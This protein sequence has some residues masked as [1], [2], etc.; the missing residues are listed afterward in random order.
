MKNIRQFISIFLCATAIT[1][2]TN[3]CDGF[4]DLEPRN[5]YTEEQVFSDA[6]L[7][8]A[9]VNQLYNRIQHAAL[10]HTTDGLTDDAYFTHN[11]GQVAVNQATITETATEW[12]DNGNAPWRWS[13]RYDGIYEANII[14]ERMGEVP[15]KAGYNLEFMKGQA[16][17]IRAHLYHELLRGFGGVPIVKALPLAQWEDMK[18]PRNTVDQVL[19]LILAD[20]TEA[21]KYLPVTVAAAQLG[22]VTKFAAT[23]LKA[24][25]QMHVASQLYH[26]RTI[27][28]LSLN[29]STKNRANLYYAA[30]TDA[31]K[32]IEEGP[33][34][35][36]DCSGPATAYDR[37]ELFK[38]IITDRTNSE[39]MF[40]RQFG[41]DAGDR[42]RMG[43]WHGPNGYNNWAGTTPSHDLVM[44]FERE[45][46]GSL[47]T[48]GMNVPGD[49]Y[50]A[51]SNSENPYLGREP[52]FYATVA[53][54][55]NEWGRAREAGRPGRVQDP[56][57]LGRLQAGHYELTA[58]GR[59]LA[60]VDPRS[61][62]TPP[63]SII[64]PRGHHGIDTRQGP[65]EDWNGSWTGYYERKLIDCA[66]EAR[67]NPQAVPWTF[68]RLAEMYLIA[69]EAH[70]ELVALGDARGNLDKAAEFINAVR[71]RVGN[72][73]VAVAIANRDYEGTEVEKMRAALRHERRVEFAYESQRYF[74]VRRWMIANETNNKELA[75]ILVIGTLKPPA[76]R[77]PNFG[78]GGYGGL[79]GKNA[80]I[81][82]VHCGDTWNYT[83]YVIRLNAR[84]NRK[85][86]NRLY[87]APITRGERQRHIPSDVE[88][89]IQNSLIVQNPGYE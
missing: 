46:D 65:I 28:T 54:D 77:G 81:P 80:T 69:A 25:I 70:I 4:M 3:G 49:T 53:T 33:F 43:L 9:Y 24:R 26:D 12:F 10:E 82:Y 29:Q 64:L 5:Q 8:Q 45:A 14:I 51:K 76:E 34:S 27:N 6:G 30:L 37:G 2:L 32:V 83:Y 15:D 47:Q 66:V 62:S 35:L 61:T 52:R 84:E 72:V 40:V 17:Y 18:T 60:I 16:Y 1:I 86:D 85:W 74:D 89:V 63:D 13:A 11:Y 20:L 38:A 68:M 78:Q 57:P 67:V 21:E 88:Q 22:R 55:G 48:E 41:I 59:R 42:N 44:A 23:G 79:G 71:S 58:G 56:T 75:G 36:I 19:D 73:D 50:V 7:F 31:L 87:F 39:Q